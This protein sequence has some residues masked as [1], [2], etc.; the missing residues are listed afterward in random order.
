MQ[1]RGWSTYMRPGHTDCPAHEGL[2]G[3]NTLST[4]PRLCV[5]LG[6]NLV[7]WVQPCFYQGKHFLTLKPLVLGEYYNDGDWISQP[8]KRKEW[9]EFGAACRL[10]SG[11]WKSVS[12]P[13]E[14][15]SPHSTINDA[16]MIFFWLVIITALQTTP[17][18]ICLAHSRM[19]DS[20]S[21]WPMSMAVSSIPIKSRH[22][23]GRS[24][25]DVH[26]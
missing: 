16:H 4:Q 6:F 23:V 24:A 20:L 5:L 1:S 9:F 25:R 3:R 26:F 17:F 13:E 11:S 18:Q 14:G 2:K 22:G 12:T 15:L 10:L 21:D 19:R 7:H 8:Q